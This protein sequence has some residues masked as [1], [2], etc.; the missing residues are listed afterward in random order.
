M[1]TTKKV[2]LQ[3]QLNIDPVLAMD[4]YQIEARIT[5]LEQRYAAIRLRIDQDPGTLTYKTL[6]EML[7]LMAKITHLFSEQVRR[8]TD[9]QQKRIKYILDEKQ[10]PAANRWIIKVNRN[11]Q[12]K[13]FNK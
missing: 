8:K 1:E 2:M 10:D 6:N 4:D 12:P 7:E 3:S 9:E 11:Y 5:Q 13:L